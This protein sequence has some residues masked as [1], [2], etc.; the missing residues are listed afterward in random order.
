MMTLILATFLTAAPAPV[1]TAQ[2]RPCVW[3][4]TCKTVV[5]PVVA[6]F[7]PCVWPKTCKSTPAPVLVTAGEYQPCVMPNKCG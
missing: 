7:Q 6:Q 3:P 1:T 5:A 4:N 2:F